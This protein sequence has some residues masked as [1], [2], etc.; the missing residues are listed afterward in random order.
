M[1]SHEVT[2]GRTVAVVIDHGEDFYTALT[3]ACQAHGIRQGYIPMFVG[4]LSSAKIV[5]TCEQIKNPL[6][7]VWSQVHLTNVEALG[8]GTL[9]YDETTDTCSPHVHIS[10]ALRARVS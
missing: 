4:G 2:V 6:A 9:A 5:G 8:A 10:V 1:R 3:E 7:P